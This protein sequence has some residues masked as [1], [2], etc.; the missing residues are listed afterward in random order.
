MI[1]DVKVMVNV[2]VLKS[3]SDC[4][5]NRGLLSPC[6]TVELDTE[7]ADV[8]STATVGKLEVSAC[9]LLQDR[10]HTERDPVATEI[11]RARK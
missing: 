2:K 6:P 4:V 7:A 10:T 1:F 11:S 3:K 8:E 9:S 5:R